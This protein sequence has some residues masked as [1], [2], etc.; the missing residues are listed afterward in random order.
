MSNYPGA[1]IPYY[2]SSL[3]YLVYFYPFLIF[4]VFMLFPIPIA[5]VFDSFR[6]NRSKILLE[7]R[8]EQKESL[9]L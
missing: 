5:V 8:L 6:S 4:T 9:F 2:K 7:D 3:F 1:V